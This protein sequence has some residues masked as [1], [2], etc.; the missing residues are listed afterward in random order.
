MRLSSQS[1]HKSKEAPRTAEIVPNTAITLEGVMGTRVSPAPSGSAL[2]FS[3]PVLSPFPP[4]LEGEGA[5]LVP[6]EVGPVVVTVNT[7]FAGRFSKHALA[8]SEASS[9]VLGA[10]STQEEKMSPTCRRIEHGIGGTHGW[11][12]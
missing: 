8:A 2:L 6:V 4:V 11:S 12:D 5:A 1:N 10:V 3:E 9:A 7:P